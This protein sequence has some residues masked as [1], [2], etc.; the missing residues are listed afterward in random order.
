MTGSD[1]V[2]RYV[3]TYNSGDSAGLGAFYAEDVVLEDPLMPEPTKGR[4]TVLAT[5]A[6]FRR[7]FPDMVWTVTGDP[8]VASGAIAWEVHA[9]GTMT[10]PMP[11]PEGEIPATGRSFAVDMGIFWTLGPDDRITEEHA[12]F[13]ATGMLAQLGLTP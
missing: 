13:D 8:V 6:A 2:Q 7:A 5:A 12:H 11:G 10:G 3:D 1:V 9:A 4:D